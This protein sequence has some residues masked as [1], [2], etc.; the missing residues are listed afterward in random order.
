MTEPKTYT[1][2]CHCGN[3]RYGVTADVASVTACNC[4]ICSKRGALWTF[5]PAEN[6]ALRAGEDDLADYQFGK[7]SIHH[8]FCRQCGVASFSRG[9]GPDGK[10]MV[11]VNIR[12]LDG[13]D[14]DALKVSSFDGRSL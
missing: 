1:G 6:F 12:C 14:L 7:K 4:S 10:E 9:A 13:L 8:L 5:V 3:V 2:G 11:A